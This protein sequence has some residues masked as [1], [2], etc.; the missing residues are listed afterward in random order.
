MNESSKLQSRRGKRSRQRRAQPAQPVLQQLPW[1]QLKYVDPPTEPLDAGGIERIHDT[2]MRILEE[3]GIDFLN[4]E[5]KGILKSAGCDVDPNS[6]RVRMDRAFIMEQVAR[7]PA[8]FT[9]TPRNEDRTIG[10]GGATAVFGP[11]GSPPNVTDLDRGRRVGNRADFQ[12]LVRL[13]QIF[14]CIHFH[15]GYPV[16]PVDIHPS[17][18]HLD[19]LFD[20]LTLTDKVVHA[21]SLGT[22][23]IEDAMEMVRIAAGLS[24]EQF[25]SRPRMFTNINSS[26]PLK[27]DWP[28][29]DGAMRMAR[30]GQPTVVAPFTLAGAMAPVTLAGALAQQTAECLSAVALPTPGIFSS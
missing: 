3:I 9:I 19:A 24:S 17:I 13:T 18:R 14:N 30:R 5:A 20:M 22:E 16:E 1:Q 8:E 7:A 28:M 15:T 6:D 11:V 27:H 29:L 2:A 21:Y 12:D 4:E 23:R 26:S 10:I 25:E